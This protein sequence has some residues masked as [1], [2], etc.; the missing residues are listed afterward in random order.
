VFF[1]TK[2]YLFQGM[3]ILQR[4]WRGIYRHTHTHKKCEDAENDKGKSQ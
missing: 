1:L 2:T 4:N 3:K